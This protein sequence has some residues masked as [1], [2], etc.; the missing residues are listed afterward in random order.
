MFYVGLLKP[1]R[2][3]SHVKLEA[4]APRHVALPPAAEAE[5]GGQVEPPSGFDPILAPEGEL[6]SRQAHSGSYPRSRRDRLLRD[7]A[8]QV[9]PSVYRSLRRCSM[10]KETASSMWSD[11]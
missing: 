9:R 11:S 6:V 7:A 3:P 5:A 8:L 4:L 1:Y 2:D 10:S